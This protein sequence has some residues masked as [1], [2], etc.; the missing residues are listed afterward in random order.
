MWKQGYYNVSAH[1]NIEI[2]IT[3]IVGL[4][5]VMELGIPQ[6]E[7]AYIYAVN[8]FNIYWTNETLLHSNPYANNNYISIFFISNNGRKIQINNNSDTECQI[9]I[10]IISM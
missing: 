5:F 9:Y 8:E 3:K 10:Q 6:G 1:T 7:N 4:I 2:D